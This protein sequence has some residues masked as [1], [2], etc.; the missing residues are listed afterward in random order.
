MTKRQWRMLI[1]EILEAR[2]EATTDHAFIENRLADLSAQLE[3]VRRRLPVEVQP[4]APSVTLSTDPPMI[5]YANLRWR[6]QNPDG[7]WRDC[8]E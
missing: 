7:T 8:I 4:P 5:D 3:D 2:N 6:T 1:T